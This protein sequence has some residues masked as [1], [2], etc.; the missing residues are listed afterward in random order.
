MIII[1]D[2]VSNYIQTQKY[3]FVSM[4]VELLFL[5]TGAGPGEQFAL[6]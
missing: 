5:L 4:T 2:I 1:I 6:R 3:K